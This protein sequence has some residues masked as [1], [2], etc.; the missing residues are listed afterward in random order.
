MDL[1]MIE[2]R[3]GY[4]RGLIIPSVSDRPSILASIYKVRRC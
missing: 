4:L 1:N 3:L 2:Y